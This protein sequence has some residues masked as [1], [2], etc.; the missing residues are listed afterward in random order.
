LRAWVIRATVSVALLV[1][2]LAFVP[3]GSVV[4]ALRRVSLWTC[5]AGLAALFVGHFLSA[6]KLRWLVGR[7]RVP[8]ATCV[9]AQYA[10]LVASL[11]FLGLAG[12]DLARLAYLAPAVGARRTA[13]AAVA[14]RII[15]TAALISLVGLALPL[16]GWPPVLNP[17]DLHLGWFALAAVAAAAALPFLVRL[18]RRSALLSRLWEAR[19]ELGGMRWRIAGAFGISC[20]VQ[21]TFVAANIGIANELGVDIGFAPWFVAWPLAKLTSI[22]PISLGGIGVREAAVVVF[23][24]SFGAPAE[25]VLASALVWQAL[26]GVSGVSG[27]ALTQFLRVE[28]PAKGV[29]WRWND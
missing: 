13:V 17:D 9:R 18:A 23:L 7:A 6:V 14:D 24:V 3:F 16:A 2:V 11:G 12:G 15:D 8:L 22:L 21:T 20:V 29:Q 10:A 27:L 19:A 5:A 25:S 28:T 1:C 26:I 4:A